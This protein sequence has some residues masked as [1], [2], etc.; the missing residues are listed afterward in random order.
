MYMDL[1]FHNQEISI[2]LC[3]ILGAAH[4]LEPGHGKTALVAHLLVGKRSLIRP[5]TLAFSTAFTHAFSILIISVLAHQLIHLALPTETDGVYRWLNLLSGVILLIIGI[6][7]LIKNKTSATINPSL[8]K[9]TTHQHVEKCSC[10]GHALR[11]I[12]KTEQTWKTIMIG[13]AVGLIPCPSALAA[14]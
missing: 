1:H 8:L 4:A 13:F 2:L 6:L 3:L 7:L 14:S 12:L 10:A 9:P 5:L 11:P